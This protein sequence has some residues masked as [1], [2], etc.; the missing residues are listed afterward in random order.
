MTADTAGPNA[1]QKQ[2]WDQTEGQHWVADAERY[3]RMLGEYGDA[4]IR[5]VAPE[6]GERALDV[7]CG[8]GALTLDLAARVGPTGAVV[9]VDLSGP[10]LGLARSRSLERN[11]GNVTFEQSDAQVDDLGEG[12]YDIVTSRFGVMF[13]DDPVAAFTNFGRAT[14]VGGRLGFVCWQSALSNEWAKLAITEMLRF[15]PMPQMP[16]PGTP[17]PLAMA[18]P[19]FT[20][21]VLEKAGWSDVEL[22]TVEVAQ[23]MGHDADD[24]VAF[25]QRGQLAKLFLADVDEATREKVWGAVAEALAP[26]QTENGVIL[27]G[28]AWLV[29]A[30]R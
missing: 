25:F 8:N 10:M 15:V 7:G 6:P 5:A 14:K 23:W 13:F 18:E 16:P 12:V 30:S 27:G 1:E 22:S 21:E 11:L 17:G 24:S 2:H 26:H 28:K 3:D 9:G 4:V 20:R 19:E 29:T